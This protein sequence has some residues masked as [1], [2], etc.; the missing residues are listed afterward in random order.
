MKPVEKKP[1]I[2]VSG[3]CAVANKVGGGFIA[4]E[5][6]D[7]NTTPDT[8]TLARISWA[9][10]ASAS[11]G[12]KRNRTLELHGVVMNSLKRMVTLR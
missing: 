3:A 10:G 4:F 1:I 11:S 12:F 6:E 7:G 2:V 9:N 5:P 8:C